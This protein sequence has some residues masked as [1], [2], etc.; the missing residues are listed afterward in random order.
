M[1]EIIFAG[2]GAGVSA[3]S[4][5]LAV[6]IIVFTAENYFEKVADDPSHRWSLGDTLGVGFLLAIAFGIAGMSLL[7]L[8]DSFHLGGPW[9]L[10]LMLTVLKV[11]SA[12]IGALIGFVVIGCLA[13]GSEPSYGYVRIRAL[14]AAS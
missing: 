6:A 12:L 14:A 8:R 5:M 13:A 3:A 1:D 11:I 7:L 9:W 2:I 4:V 10:V